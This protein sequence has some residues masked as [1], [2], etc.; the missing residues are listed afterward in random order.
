MRNC[1]GR[2]MWLNGINVITNISLMNWLISLPDSQDIY[3]CI[4]THKTEPLSLSWILW[5]HLGISPHGP[6]YVRWFVNEQRCNCVSLYFSVNRIGMIC[7]SF[8]KVWENMR[9]EKLH[10]L[11][12]KQFNRIDRLLMCTPWGSVLVWKLPQHCHVKK[13][14]LCSRPCSQ[15]M[16]SI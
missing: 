8:A 2:Y 9:F 14:G 7:W 6:Q 4:K 12:H 10:I 5:S 15:F 13:A 1:Q 11:P 16:F 3:F